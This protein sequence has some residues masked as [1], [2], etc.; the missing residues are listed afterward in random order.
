VFQDAPFAPEM[1][2]VPPGRFMMGSKGG[3]GYK[4]ERP[5][6]EETI[7][8]ALA[9]G[10]YPVTFEEWDFA[11]SDKEWKRLTGV[12]ARKPKDEGWGRER[13]PVIDV[14]WDDAQAYTTWLSHKTGQPYRLLSE[15]EWEYACRAGSEAAYCFGDDEAE[16]GDYAWYEK[17]SGFRTH[18]VGEKKPNAFGLYDMHGNVW[19]WCLDKVRPYSVEPA[20]DPVGPLDSASRALRGGSWDI[21]ARYLRAA[22]RSGSAR[23]FRLRNFGFRCAC[24]R[25]PRQA[26]MVGLPGACRAGGAAEP[27]KHRHAGPA[28]LA[29]RAR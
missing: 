28:E 3:E 21:F 6:H 11:Q 5:R 18:P 13:R 20:I 25:E 24:V 2:M 29:H 19:E 10:R 26:G 8:R 27:R 23:E 12:K 17:N 16:L 14:S 9:V 4:D 1:V 15:A 22:D 7:P